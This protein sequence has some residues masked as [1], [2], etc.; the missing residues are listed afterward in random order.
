[1]G[2]PSPSECDLCARK[3]GCMR[4]GD[5]DDAAR[6]DDDARRGDAAAAFGDDDAAFGDDDA[7]AALRGDD[8]D[9]ALCCTEPLD[10]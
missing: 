2:A 10:L 7:D 3:R 1:M 5:L 9:T 8:A 6:G 4:A